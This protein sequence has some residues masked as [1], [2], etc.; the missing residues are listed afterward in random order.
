MLGASIASFI[1]I[2]ASSIFGMPISGTHTV[3]GALIGAGIGIGA[4]EAINW[5][6]LSLIIASWF[7]APLTSL[8]IS[9]IFYLAVNRLTLKKKAEQS[10]C[11]RLF[12]Q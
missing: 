12:W 4:T 6:K 7:A 11:S 10:C 9:G 5:K 8:L 1:F 2:M 3:V